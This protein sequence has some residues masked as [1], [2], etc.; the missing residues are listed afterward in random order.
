MDALESSEQQV[1]RT[2]EEARRMHPLAPTTA[3]LT[4]FGR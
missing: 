2:R 4:S 1:F 3:W